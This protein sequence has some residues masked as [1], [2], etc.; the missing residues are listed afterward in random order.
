[1]TQHFDKISKSEENAAEL[2]TNKFSTEH[3]RVA[4]RREALQNKY[5]MALPPPPPAT[6]ISSNT[7]FYVH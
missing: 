5:Y 6:K 4:N 3:F 2:K 7:L 1:M